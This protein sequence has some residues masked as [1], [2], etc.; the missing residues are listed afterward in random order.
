M[1]N[2]CSSLDDGVGDGGDDG[3]DGLSISWSCHQCSLY[4][5]EKNL[6]RCHNLLVLNVSLQKPFV[7]G[8]VDVGDAA[9]EE[10]QKNRAVVV[11]TKV[12]AGYLLIGIY[13]WFLLGR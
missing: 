1:R 4:H 3:G 6:P 2:A 8:S 7:L 11:L 5:H 9:D 13:S 12:T 10:N